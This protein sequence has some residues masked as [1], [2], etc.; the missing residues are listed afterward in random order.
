MKKALLFLPVALIFMILVGTQQID[1]RQPRQQKK[2]QKAPTM[3]AQKTAPLSETEIQKAQLGIAAMEYHIHW[4]EDQ[5]AYSSPNRKNNLRVTYRDDGFSLKPRVDTL[6]P[7]KLDYQVQGIFRGEQE[8][9]AL[10]ESPEVSVTDQQLL[11]HHEDGLHIEY[12]NTAQGMR[13]NFILDHRPEGEGD[14]RVRLQ[15]TG[16]LYPMLED[17][18]SVAMMGASGAEAY[19]RDLKVFDA[20]GESVT[21][22]M[23]V[24][25][26][27]F[28]SVSGTWNGGV[29]LVV[30]DFGV[31]YPLLVDPVS[32]TAG[33][34]LVGD[35]ASYF[36]SSAFSAGD[37][38]GDGYSDMV[39]GAQAY[40]NGETDE[41]AIFVYYGSS[42]GF[43][44]TY[45]AIIESNVSGSL[46]G[47]SVSTACDA[48]GDGISDV[49]AGA[50][51]YQGTG[52]AFIFLGTLNGLDTIPDTILTSFLAGSYFGLSVSGVGDVNND[53]FSDI[54]IGA[55]FGSNPESGEGLAM[56]YYG[57]SCPISVEAYHNLT[58]SLP[59]PNRVGYVRKLCLTD[60]LIIEQNI[61]SAGFGS[62]VSAAAD[63]N[64]DG[65]SDVIIQSF[66][67]QGVG[68]S[69]LYYGDSIGVSSPTTIPL[70][71]SYVRDPSHFGENGSSVVS[72][73][74]VDGDG[75]ADVAVARYG[76][77]AYR[78]FAYI[79]HGT[80][81]GLSI[82]SPD[83]LSR[84]E[85]KGYQSTAADSNAWSNIPDMQFVAEYTV[86]SAG[87]WNGDGFADVMVGRACEDSAQQQRGILIYFGSLAGVDSLADDT[88]WFGNY[89]SQLDFPFS[90]TGDVNGDGYSDVFVGAP[91]D[92]LNGPFDVGAVYSFY[93][94]PTPPDSS[95]PTILTCDSSDAVFGFQIACV[96]DLNSDGFGD[97]VAGAGGYNGGLGA[98]FL[99][100]GA[101]TGLDSVTPYIISAPIGQDTGFGLVPAGAG[102]LN[103]DGYEDL[104]VGVPLFSNNAQTVAEG[105]VFVYYGS[106]TGLVTTAFTL[107]ESNQDS[108][109]MGSGVSSAGDVNG[110]GF[111]DLLVGIP[112]YDH[113]QVD[114]GAAFL[115]FGDSIG[116]D[117]SNYQI[118]DS[119][120]PSQTIGLRVG[121]AGDLNGDGFGDIVLGT[122]LFVSVGISEGALVYL[123][124]PTGADTT[125]KMMFSSG[126]DSFRLGTSVTSLGDVNA[127]GYDEL[128]IG[129]P[130]YSSSQQHEGAVYIYHGSDTGIGTIPTAIVKSNQAEATLGTSVFGGDV[131][132]DGYNDL[133]AGALFDSTSFSNEGA[134][135]VYLGSSNGIDTTPIFIGNSGIAGANMGLSVSTG[136]LNGDSY[137]DVC[138]SAH[139]YPNGGAVFVY[140]GN[141][142]HGLPIRSMQ[143]MPSDSSPIGPGGLADQ[144]GKITLAG[145]GK[146]FLGRQMGRFVYEFRTNGQPFSSANGSVTNSVDSSGMSTY[147]DLAGPD[148]TRI[149]QEV[150]GLTNRYDYEWRWRIQY[151]KAT[152]ITGQVFGPWHYAKNA[153]TEVPGHGFKT[154]DLCGQELDVYGNMIAIQAADITP[155]VGDQTDF[156]QTFLCGDSI[157]KHYTL[158]NT[159]Y[160]NL[161]LDSLN[162]SG[163]NAASFEIVSVEDSIILPG[164]TT[165]IA[166]RLLPFVEGNIHA[167]V[168]LQSNDCNESHYT[169]A[170]QA[171]VYPDTVL[172]II[173]CPHDTI[174]CDTLLTWAPA[175]ATDNCGIAQLDSTHSFTQP[176]FVGRNF[177][178]YSATD[179][180]GNTSECTFEVLVRPLPPPIIEPETDT[181]YC[182]GQIARLNLRGNYASIQ[183][184]N[185]ATNDSISLTV[186]Q[187]D[188]VHVTVT[189]TA[190]CSSTARAIITAYPPINA[191]LDSLDDTLFLHTNYAYYQWYRDTIPL[192]YQIHPTLAPHL[193]GFYHVIVTDQNGCRDTS[194][195]LEFVPLCM[196]SEDYCIVIYPNP[197]VHH[198]LLRTLSPIPSTA[199]IHL[200]I[201]DIQGRQVWDTIANEL[202]DLMPIDVARFVPAYYYLVVNIVDGPKKYH[203]VFLF[204]RRDEW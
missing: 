177:V 202:L 135:W 69:Y 165:Q 190:G 144:S 161:H 37:V 96:G 66:D 197:V 127:D 46:L 28:D 180:S 128:A 188:T 104:A 54:L 117:T 201:Y 80:P 10:S 184:S 48:N 15:T 146:S 142:G 12:N 13:Q 179:L 204:L 156:G 112:R 61:S 31:V 122:N 185:G 67:G 109:F 182:L 168:N 192:Q 100:Y 155:N 198:L 16:D 42:N 181:N 120:I 176:F 23:E 90:S 126:Q 76:G 77:S 24:V 94:H 64:G 82:N 187:T 95:N 25:A 110:D 20:N 140:Y 116:I 84:E 52:A 89:F 2:A 138:A 175:I 143:L 124:S 158:V 125:T 30:Q 26:A 162:I 148:T 50:P 39:I 43:V 47:Y 78:P 196:G 98:F 35:S 93:G 74:D 11:Q 108:A 57:G 139:Y 51:G 19:Y 44:S 141:A 157:L 32:L 60:P 130:Y 38:N 75:F 166:I 171:Y 7:W 147:I 186:T 178:A 55:M 17:S 183:W 81:N 169:F 6:N 195:A 163:P 173:T 18:S 121:S 83:I 72:V 103:G 88:V 71:N 137:A 79:F 58:D 194:D 199:T 102:D 105:S 56:L 115:Y 91:D 159:G 4:Q 203:K 21:A 118:L 68:A 63:I 45:L 193:P 149:I 22:F 62:T 59:R 170:I 164:D 136:D 189:D 92:S 167:T 33:D 5:Q 129:V 107:I 113:G 134:V 119:D 133:I 99:Y 151:H 70:A 87:D 8:V 41:G 152:A 132:G 111:G 200:Q 29:D 101:E 73:G 97:F 174:T 53:G 9:I 154:I 65:Y 34:T 40:D 27:E 85:N 145:Q 131:N 36:A 191:V 86:G 106:D 172:P 14:L 49:V 1:H 153:S 160:A 123:G 3:A 150:S 114:E